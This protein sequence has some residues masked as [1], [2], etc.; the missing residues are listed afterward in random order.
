MLYDENK[1]QFIMRISPDKKKYESRSKLF[2]FSYFENFNFE[3]N[4]QTITL[5]YILILFLQDVKII[6]KN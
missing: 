6:F 1:S 5:T 3:N 2:L 4:F